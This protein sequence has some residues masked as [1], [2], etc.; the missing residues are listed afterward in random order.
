[1]VPLAAASGVLVLPGIQGAPG[2]AALWSTG[3]MTAAFY[4]GAFELQ[5]RGGAVVTGQLGY[6]ITLASLAIGALLLGETHP[7][8]TWIGAAL[9]IAGVVLVLRGGAAREPQS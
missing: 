2:S 3:A 1:V 6:V 7:A 9:A 5:R 8:S 4:L